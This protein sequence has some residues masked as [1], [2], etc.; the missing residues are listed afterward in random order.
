MNQD[1]INRLGAPFPF[2]EVEAKIQVTTGDKKTGMVVFY[3]DS[4]AVQNRLD[5]VVG[6]FN[7]SNHF[8]SWQDNSQICGI[9]IFNQERSEWITKHDGAENSKIESIKG[10]LTDAFKRAAV[11]W[12]IGR[13][14][15]QIDGVWVEVEQ[16]GNSSVIKSNQQGKLK[17]AYDNAVKRI[18]GAGQHTPAENNNGAAASH[19]NPTQKT[20]PQPKPAPPAAPHTQNSNA[21]KNPAASQETQVPPESQTPSNGQPPQD[22]AAVHVFKVHSSKAAG[23]GSHILELCNKAGEITEA[24]IRPGEPSPTIGTFLHN[25]KIESKTG[26]YGDYNMVTCYDIAA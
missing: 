22:K 21:S 9:S 25:V 15:Y 14:L 11:L 6:I 13:Y 5:D 3:L 20:T 4:R 17:A 18:F 19:S 26:K 24:Y 10:G 8:S 23:G 2:E 7:W 1:K 12:G 16:R